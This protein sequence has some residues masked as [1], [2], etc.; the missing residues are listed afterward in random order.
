MKTGL[1]FAQRRPS[2]FCDKPGHH[3]VEAAELRKPFRQ[4]PVHVQSVYRSLDV[5]W[6]QMSD[7]ARN[8]TLFRLNAARSRLDANAGRV[9]QRLAE[10]GAEVPIYAPR[11]L[12]AGPESIP[13]GSMG[14]PGGSKP[15]SADAPAFKPP[16]IKRLCQTPPVVRPAGAG[17]APAANRRPNCNDAGQQCSLHGVSFCLCGNRLPRGPAR[18][19]PTRNKARQ[20]FLTTSWSGGSEILKQTFADAVKCPTKGLF[21]WRCAVR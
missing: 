10:Q 7:V 5:H 18:S 13:R 16:S 9:L 4:R 17:R 19:P 20:N 2:T 1:A 14:L 12:S 21:P 15:I 11:A 3:R 6:S 8:I